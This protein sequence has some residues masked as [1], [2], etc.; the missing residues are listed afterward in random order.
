[1]TIEEMDRNLG[2][3]ETDNIDEAS[4]LA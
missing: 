3:E 4:K 1:V 2:T